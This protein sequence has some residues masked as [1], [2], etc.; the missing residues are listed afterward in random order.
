MA[1]PDFRC[2]FTW[3][4]RDGS[5]AQFLT[6]FKPLGWKGTRMLLE[7]HEGHSVI[8]KISADY[9]FIG[10]AQTFLLAV[11]AQDGP[12]AN[13]QFVG[14]VSFD[15]GVFE[16]LFNMQLNMALFSDLSANNG[17]PYKFTAPTFKEDTWQ[18]FINRQRSVI[19]IAGNNMDGEAVDAP[20]TK[21]L[22]LNT[23]K[24]RQLFSAR[25]SSSLFY[26]LD[27][28]NLYGIPV[29]DVVDTD[30]IKSR[31]KFD[32]VVTPQGSVAGVAVLPDAFWTV[33]WSGSY[34]F[35]I[36]KTISGSVPVLT[37]LTDIAAYI[38]INDA[39]PIA[40]TLSQHSVSGNDF[41]KLS[42]A[43]SHTLVRGDKVRIWFEY[44]GA[45]FRQFYW[46]ST[47]SFTADHPNVF[48]VTA[49]TT[50]DNTECESLLAHDAGAALTDRIL[51]P[52]KFYS[53]F[54]GHTTLTAALAV[55]YTE[56]GCGYRY[57]LTRGNQLRGNTF[58]AKPWA[59]S[60]LEWFE[61]LDAIHMLGYGME[62]VTGFGTPVIVVHGREHFYD[63]AS[64]MTLLGVQ[65]IKRSRDSSLIN[66]AVNIGYSAAECEEFGVLDDAHGMVKYNT[67]LRRVGETK[68][69]QSPLIAAGLVIEATRRKQIEP[70]KD[71]RFDNSVFII[72]TDG[73]DGAK[74]EPEFDAHFTGLA[75]FYNTDAR[76]NIRLWPIFNL[77][78]NLPSLIIGLAHWLDTDF[79]FSTGNLNTLVE[80]EMDA[81]TD[82][83]Y[84]ADTA[85]AQNQDVA[86]NTTLSRGAA[87]H[88]DQVYDFSHPLAYS[89]YKVIRSNS[90][91]AIGVVP[92][93]TLS[94]IFDD[95]FDFTFNEAPIEYRAFIRTVD[96]GVF[97][98][99][100]EFSLYKAVE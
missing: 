24:I 4:P 48:D 66:R 54:F 40:F 72:S 89:E 47:Q 18:T 67:G 57:A 99:R 9:T 22:K 87:L 39:A 41:S 21:T 96:W 16:V 11:D 88:S 56:N 25:R 62:I 75:G 100:A 71:W 92:E 53:P 86:L 55:A 20:N 43:A 91:M 15:E 84:T 97:E 63:S 95:T 6:G 52:D 42:Y 31:N 50:F 51:G 14:E 27:T 1:T 83:I 61:S 19:N 44:T 69:I 29:P 59:W 37:Q 13:V 60:W 77:L 82:C 73:L 68:T 90:N 3:T 70:S 64:S 45:T 12:D 65:S 26:D 79:I 30:E 80:G 17:I 32:N 78:R 35:N 74:L 5:G 49:D 33:E 85:V 8:E 2:S 46:I 7:R 36:I 38:Q 58:S 93:G 81:A 76:Y 94:G 98:G 10:E 34:A 23:Q 28:T